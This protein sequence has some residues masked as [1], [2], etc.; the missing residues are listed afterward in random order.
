MVSLAHLRLLALSTC[1]GFGTVS[2]GLSLEAFLGGAAFAGASSPWG[3]AASALSLVPG[4]FSCPAACG[5]AP[6]IPSA[7]RHSNPRP[8]V[9]TLQKHGNINPFPIDYAFRPRLRDRLTPGGRTCPGNPWTFGETDFHRLFR[10][11]CLHSHS[12]A[13]QIGFRHTF[14]AHT[15][16]SY[17]SNNGIRGFGSALSPDHFRR[18]ISRPVSFYAL[19]K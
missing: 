3:D 8:S 13:L 9:A 15:T 19:F 14:A 2:A 6:A 5:L 4:G 12:Y 7:G 1:V 17:H 10:Y 11:S 18:G 16:L